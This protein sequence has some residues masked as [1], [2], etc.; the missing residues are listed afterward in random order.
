MVEMT[1]YYG[2]GLR[3]VENEFD[4]MMVKADGCSMGLDGG[5]ETWVMEIERNQEFPVKST[6]L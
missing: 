6:F 5:L 1:M 4:W 3:S 2:V